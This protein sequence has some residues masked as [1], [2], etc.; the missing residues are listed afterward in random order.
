MKKNSETSK[1]RREGF[2]RKAYKAMP[3]ALVSVLRQRIV[4]VT[5]AVIVKHGKTPHAPQLRLFF[6][7]LINKKLRKNCHFF[8]I[9]ITMSELGSPLLVS[10]EFKYP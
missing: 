10:F 6:T 8:L 2:Y 1:K 3:D 4:F 5:G 9:S 7:T